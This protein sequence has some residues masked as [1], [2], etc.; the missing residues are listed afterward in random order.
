MDAGFKLPAL[1]PKRKRSKRA[2]QRQ[3]VVDAAGPVSDGSS[4]HFRRSPGEM[5]PFRTSRRF[6]R[7]FGIYFST[8][9]NFI[10]C[11]P[12]IWRLFVFLHRKF[13]PESRIFEPRTLKPIFL[14]IYFFSRRRWKK[15]ISD[16]W[17][18]FQIQAKKICPV[19]VIRHQT[20][21]VCFFLPYLVF[22]MCASDLMFDGRKLGCFKLYSGRQSFTGRLPAR[23]PPLTPPL[24]RKPK[25][26]SASSASKHNFI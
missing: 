3:F 5:K 13:L 9:D 22:L 12:N 23:F 1:I 4:Q 20:D 26:K 18:I 17:L 25:M 24:S 7:F 10:I 14:F 2:E 19:A 15:I 11:L 16:P 8:S 6:R 21:A